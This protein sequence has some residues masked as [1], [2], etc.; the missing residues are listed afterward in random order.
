MEIEQIHNTLERAQALL[1]QGDTSTSVLADLKT[2]LAVSEKSSNLDLTA[3]ILSCIA[4]FHMVAGDR[5]DALKNAESGLSAVRGSGTETEVD[6]LVITARL[7]MANDVA[8]ALSLLEEAYG[9]SKRLHGTAKPHVILRYGEALGASGDLN[10]AIA[11]LRMAEQLYELADDLVGRANVLQ[12]MCVQL[13][14]ASHYAEAIEYASETLQVA[15]HLP[16]PL[17][18][19]NALKFLA[20][21]LT[22]AGRLAE[23]FEVARKAL[24]VARSRPESHLVADLN[25]VLGDIYLDLNDHRTALTLFS[26]AYQHYRH[27]GFR[28]G[29]AICLSR[30]AET[31]ARVG[32][33]KQA[34]TLFERAEQLSL[35]VANQPIYRATV[36]VHAA[37]YVRQGREEEAD[38]LL[39]TI[40]SSLRTIQ[41][42]TPSER[43]I[44]EAIS[45]FRAITKATT[46]LSL[47]SVDDLLTSSD[48][49]HLQQPDSPP[50]P[51]RKDQTRSVDVQ[52]LGGFRVFRHGVEITMEEWKRK[53]ARDLFKLLAVHHRRSMTIDEIV[54]KLWGEDVTV[55]SCLPTLQNAVSAIRTALEPELKPRQTSSFITFR[56]GSYVLDLG[57][58]AF[59]DLEQFRSAL[60]SAFADQD[61]GERRKL[62]TQATLLYTGDLLPDDRFEQWTDFVRDEVRQMCSDAYDALAAVCFELGDDSAAREAM[63]KAAQFEE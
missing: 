16:N 44:E 8:R 31:Y 26:A 33:F 47:P 32:E 55:E 43:S 36:I 38:R 35:Q 39:N 51:K 45:T 23:A 20:I 17:V 57:P 11:H 15:D 6:L 28:N 27:R 41:S 9:W 12:R 49:V 37:M 3:K 46:S 2:C 21:A 7:I 54:M 60:T 34:E 5:S 48:T 14:N 62:L 1:K 63:R 61:A 52:L 18:R 10:G 40:H 22:K 59:V 13:I 53:K 56:D 42:T 4:G 24:D 50:E 29:E 19:I 30:M 25:G 58:E